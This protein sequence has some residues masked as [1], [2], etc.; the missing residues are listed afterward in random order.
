[1][2]HSPCWAEVGLVT[3]PAGQRLWAQVQHAHPREERHTEA[4]LQSEDS[5]FTWSDLGPQAGDSPSQLGKATIKHPPSPGVPV[6]WKLAGGGASL[7]NGPTP[8]GRAERGPM[9]MLP[10]LDPAKEGSQAL[11][12]P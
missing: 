1:M 2:T 4:S 12:A 6:T 3:L 10:L 7:R 5:G 9:E 8:P 11:L